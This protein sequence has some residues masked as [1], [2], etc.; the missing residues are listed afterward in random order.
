MSDVEWGEFKLGDLFDIENTLSFNTDKLVAGDTYDYVTRTSMNQGILQTTGFVNE[1]NINS[2]GTWSLGLL[3][4]D[5]FYRR[6]PW[7]AGQFI[8]KITPKIPIK[9]S[10]VEF[11]TIVL[12]KLKKKLLTVLVRDVDELFCNSTI[13]LPMKN[14]E[15]D[16]E[17]MEYILTTTVKNSVNKLDIYL[18]N[19]GLKDYELTEEEKNVLAEYEK[20][21]H[22]EFNVPEIFDVK[23]TSNLLSSDIVPDS[24][25]TPY[26]CASAEN[27]GVST[28]TTYDERFLEKGNCIFIGGKTFVVSYQAKDFFSNDSHNIVLYLKDGVRTKLNQLYIATCVYKSLSHK[29]SWGDSVSKTKIKNDK[30][31]LPVKNGKPY[32][33]FMETFITAIQKLVIKDVVLYAD[34][35][36][37]ATKNTI[38]NYSKNRM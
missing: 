16:F 31:L 8:R 11:F 18:T 37:E 34:S 2:A 7:Y 26:L 28:Y 3:Q 17:F 29:Y 4:M 13:C 35:K 38:N 20:L 27:N 1:E 23:N 25:S 21:E 33:D 5:F 24:G 36:L 15:I 10:C 9:D 32:L 19:S 30:V 12:N 14:G 22:K 6:K